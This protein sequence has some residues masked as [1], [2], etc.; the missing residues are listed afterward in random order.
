MSRYK[1]ATPHRAWQRPT[2]GWWRRHPVDLRYMLREATALFVTAYALLLLGGLV[3]LWRGEAAYN[4]WRALLATPWSV[5]LHALALVAVAWHA[6]TW[7]QVMPK[8]APPLPVPPRL[9]TLAGMA[10]SVV[11]QLALLAVLWGASR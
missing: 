6:I 9:L 7:F 11:L 8:T 4:A 10:L 5:G 3:C 2:A 1:P